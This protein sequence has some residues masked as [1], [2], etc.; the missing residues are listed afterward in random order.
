MKRYSIWLYISVI[1]AIFLSVIYLYEF[2]YKMVDNAF[3]ISDLEKHD[4]FQT[5]KN[6][7]IDYSPIAIFILFLAAYVIQKINKK[8]NPNSTK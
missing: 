3:R 4:G 7:S 5:I 6:T 8:I 2:G 1:V